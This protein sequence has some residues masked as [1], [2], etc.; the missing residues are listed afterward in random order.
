MKRYNKLVWLGMLI[1]FLEVL[2]IQ[3]YTYKFFRRYSYYEYQ[4]SMLEQILSIVLI[5]CIVA[6]ILQAITVFVMFKYPKSAMALAYV[7]T[8]FT[9]PMGFVF[10]VGFLFTREKFAYRELVEFDNDEQDKLEI[11]LLFNT[12]KLMSLGVLFAVLGVVLVLLG[13]G[14]GTLLLSLGILNIIHA[15]RLKNVVSL[16]LQG[17]ELVITPS[18]Y[19][20]TYRIPVKNVHVLKDNKR[21][22]KLCL[23]M[24]DSYENSTLQKAQFAGDSVSTALDVIMI[25][26][27]RKAIK[28]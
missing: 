8:F 14:M 13:I 2:A 26:L 1:V 23:S 22:M 4:E 20:A 7:S 10:F 17:E 15:K 25:T 5:L 11:K 18:L 16:G 24:S 6:I 3:W 19:S 9:L 21:I 27:T 12:S 28:N